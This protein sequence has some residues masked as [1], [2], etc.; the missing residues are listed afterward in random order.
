MVSLVMKMND[1]MLKKAH[2]SALFSYY[3]ALLTKKQQ[4]LFVA[5]YEED[6]SLAEISESFQISRNAVYDHLCKA[7]QK[8]DQLE[9]NLKLLEKATKRQALMASYENNQIG[10]E[11]FLNKLKEME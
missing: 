10:K 7:T 4:E 11:E 5:Y 6:Y 9:A 2:Y 8:L 1:L 3:G